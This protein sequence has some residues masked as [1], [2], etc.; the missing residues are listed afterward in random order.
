MTGS[1]VNPRL[2]IAWAEKHLERLNRE[3]GAFFESNK[4]AVVLEPDLLNQRYSIIYNE[5]RPFDPTW[6]LIVGDIAH[7]ARSALDHL[8]WQLVLSN[9]QT[10][11][12]HNSFPIFVRPERWDSEITNRPKKRG[13]GPLEGVSV[14][15]CAL[16]KD[17]QPYKGRDKSAARLIPLAR[18]AYLNNT[19][20]HRSLVPAALYMGSGGLDKVRMK[21]LT[22]GVQIL[23]GFLPLPGTP[24]ERNTQIGWLQL[25]GP[26]GKMQVHLDFPIEVAFDEVP[27]RILRQAIADIVKIINRFEFAFV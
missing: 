17:L 19:D 14:K 24:I 15:S 12:K 7:N 10:P 16:I 26:E 6:G 13:P 18:V 11:G 25:V 27:T 1:L 22:P 2:K 3:L 4:D 23:G 21:F 9:G 8:V 5:P 20:K